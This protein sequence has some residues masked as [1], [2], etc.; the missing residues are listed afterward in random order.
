MRE[1]ERDFIGRVFRG[2]NAGHRTPTYSANDQDSLDF[3]FRNCYIETF[4]RV[5]I[6]PEKYSFSAVKPPTTSFY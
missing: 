4:S 3:D 5:S 1:R 6:C 2:Q